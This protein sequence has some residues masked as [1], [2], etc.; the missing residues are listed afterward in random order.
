M[1]GNNS[2]FSRENPFRTPELY[3]EDL[4]DKVMERISRLNE[5][6]KP[7]FSRTYIW[8][9]AI[10]MALLVVS[11]M[12]FNPGINFSGASKF[13]TAQNTYI[14]KFDETSIVNTLISEE[15]SNSKIT[16]DIDPINSIELTKA[17]LIDYLIFENEKNELFY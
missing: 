15:A 3:F 17:E 11:L 9:P 14:M 7:G 2:E 13:Q 5:S 6:R 16:V 10:G 4:P 12:I 1:H 8:A